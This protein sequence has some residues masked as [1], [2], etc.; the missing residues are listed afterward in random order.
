VFLYTTVQ[1]FGDGKIFKMSLKKVFDRR[2]GC[3]RVETMIFI[4]WIIL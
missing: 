3:A 4:F 1:K 2:D